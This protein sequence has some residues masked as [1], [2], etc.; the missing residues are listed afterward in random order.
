MKN[1]I[2]TSESFSRGN[3]HYFFDYKRAINSSNFISL[4]L[5]EAQHCGGYGRQSIPVFE[6][7]FGIFIES[8][9]SLITSIMHYG[10]AYETVQDMWALGQYKE[11]LGEHGIKG[12][13]E[14]ERPR[15]KMLERG[16]GRMTDSELLAMLIGSGTPG[17][18]AIELAHRILQSVEWKL[19]GLAALDFSGL[20]RFSGMGIAKSS[21]IMA[22]MELGRRLGRY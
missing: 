4:T 3:K 7:D 16:A 6:E 18:N 2:L 1:N 21:S 10:K 9:S 11:R 5:S 13:Q 20:C 22:A 14:G 19:K 8:F 17:E 15:E 12:M